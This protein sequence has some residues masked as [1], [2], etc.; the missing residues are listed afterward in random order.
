[1]KIIGEIGKSFT[2]LGIGMI[3]IDLILVVLIIALIKCMK[4][5]KIYEAFSKQ[6]KSYEGNE[7]LETKDKVLK[8][9]VDSF[10]RAA[11]SGISKINLN[12]IINKNLDRELI[13]A[14][15]SIKVY[16]SLIEVLGVI[17]TFL[18]I[19]ITTMEYKNVVVSKII[20]SFWPIMF[21]MGAKLLLE[22][23]K[24]MIIKRK[25]EFYFLLEDY[26]ENDI[27]SLYREKQNIEITKIEEL[28]NKIEE[29]E[30]VIK[31]SS[32]NSQKFAAILNDSTN[33][34]RYN[35]NLLHSDLNKVH[36]LLKSRW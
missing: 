24:L 4:I 20:I 2:E 28:Q 6:L 8:S 26:L 17:G 5:K 33:K 1:M 19:M 10:I 15:K 7:Q 31:E 14:E 30:K 11:E 29:L 35:F 32:I 25:E 34:I 18:S 9:I 12:A 22:I 36:E 21:V 27:Y 3:F 16:G 13:N 23:V